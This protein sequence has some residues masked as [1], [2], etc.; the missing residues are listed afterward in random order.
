MGKDSWPLGL[1]GNSVIIFQAS[2][3]S[4]VSLSAIRAF[5]P[6]DMFT[7]T[8]NLIGSFWTWRE[9]IKECFEFT[10]LCGT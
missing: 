9:P 5:I 4:M 8:S 10:H 7:I 3:S 6:S 1:P 2:G